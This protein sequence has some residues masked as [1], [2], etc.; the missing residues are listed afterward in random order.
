VRIRK[1]V[2][3]LM[4]VEGIVV[5][6][7]R[8]DVSREVLVVVVRARRNVTDQRRLVALAGSMCLVSFSASGA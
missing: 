1:I 6:D 5:E 2:G 3:M 8:V 7:L 4:G